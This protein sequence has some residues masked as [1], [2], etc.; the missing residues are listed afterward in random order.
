M[1]E[2]VE[3]EKKTGD[4]ETKKKTKQI[5]TEDSAKTLNTTPPPMHRTA[6]TCT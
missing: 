5:Q 2:D 3:P 1:K 4:N 6:G